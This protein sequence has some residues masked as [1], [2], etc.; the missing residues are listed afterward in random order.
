MHIIPVFRRLRQEN[1]KLFCFAVLGLEHRAFTLSHSTHPFFMKGIFE[2][3]SQKLL[4]WSW[5]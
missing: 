4:A 1:H 2:I 3:G 5:L